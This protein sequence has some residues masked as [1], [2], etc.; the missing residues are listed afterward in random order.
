MTLEPK[1]VL[2][3]QFL[4]RVVRKECRHLA[5]YIQQNRHCEPHQRRA[6]PVFPL[7]L[8]CH[9][10]SDFAMTGLLPATL[11]SRSDRRMLQ[12]AIIWLI[13]T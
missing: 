8:D 13:K 2:R 5:D 10:P 12:L 1:M 7:F 9:S 3:L 4:A 11:Y 6:N